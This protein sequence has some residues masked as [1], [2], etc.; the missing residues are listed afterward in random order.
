MKT[1]NGIEAVAECIGQPDY[2][3]S[4]DDPTWTFA[5]ALPHTRAARAPAKTGKGN[6]REDIG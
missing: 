3:E 2:Q 5:V 6:E 4:S 1:E